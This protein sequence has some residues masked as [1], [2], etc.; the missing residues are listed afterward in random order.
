MLKS[1]IIKAYVSTAHQTGLQMTDESAETACKILS[2]FETPAVLKALERCLI[3]LR[4]PLTLGAVIDRLDDGFP[5][6]ETAWAMVAK[7]DDGGTVVWTDEIA[8]SYAVVQHMLTDHVAARLAFLENYRAKVA[9][10]RAE[11]RQPHWWVSLGWDGPGRATA[12][13]EAVTLKRLSRDQARQM[14]PPEAIPLEWREQKSLP[15]HASGDFQYLTP[16]ELAQQRKL[17]ADLTGVVTRRMGAKAGEPADEAYFNRLLGR[18][19]TAPE[20]PANAPRSDDEA[21]E[22]V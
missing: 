15:E 14:L 17:I 2:R 18:P 10:A 12:L 13:L 20:T 11:A 9:E 3:E 22:R 7:L 19:E 5:G 4:V 21:S 6:P 8:E 1:E 16:D